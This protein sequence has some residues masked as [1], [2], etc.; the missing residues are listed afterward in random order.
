MEKQRGSTRIWVQNGGSMGQFQGRKCIIQ[1][2]IQS[3]KLDAAIEHEIW[4]LNVLGGI[5]H[6]VELFREILYVK[7]FP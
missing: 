7:S 2:F 4:T 6:I 5:T 3:G 1:T